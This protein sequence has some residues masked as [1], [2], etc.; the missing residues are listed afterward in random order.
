MT[1]EMTTDEA[2]AELGHL[3]EDAGWRVDRRAGLLRVTNRSAPALNER[4]TVQRGAFYWSWGQ[5]ITEMRN[6]TKAAEAVGR[7]LTTA[8]GAEDRG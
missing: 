3:L 5:P 8:S 1:S 2:L 6:V 7:V 4:I